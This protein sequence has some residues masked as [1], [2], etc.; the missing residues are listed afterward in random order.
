MSLRRVGSALGAMLRA[1]SLAFLVP[2][3]AA[4]VWEPRDLLVAGNAIPENTATFV[5][6]FLAI[7]LVAVPLGLATRSA[8]EED[9]T[10]REGYLTVALAWVLVP[11]F[12]MLPFELASAHPHAFDAYVEAMAAL[13]TTGFSTLADPG[14]M[15]P[16]LLLWRALLQWMGGLAIVALGMA[17]LSKLTHGGLRLAPSDA[18]VQASKRLRPKMMDTARSLLI[19]YASVTLVLLAV[20]AAILAGEGQAV[21]DAILDAA[22]LTLGA[23]STGGLA[24]DASVDHL[25]I[26]ALAVVAVGM[27]LGATSYQVVIAARSGNLRAALRDPEWRF[28]VGALAI[29]GLGLALVLLVAGFAPRDALLD[30]VWTAVSAITGTGFRHAQPGQ[31]PL[32]AQF[33]LLA[34]LVVGGSSGSA[35]GGVKLFRILILLKM[36]QRQ[37]RIL[38]HPRAVAPVRVGRTVVPDAALAT[39]VAFTF[40]YILLWL[41]GT[42]VLAALEPHL[43][44]MALASGAAASLGNVGLPFGGFAPEG[45]IAALGAGSK[46]VITFLMWAGRLEIFAALLLFYPASWRA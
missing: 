21:R 31:W 46:A 37:L 44:P 12:A 36:V 15:P 14:A 24:R 34:L 1:V 23:F 11:V 25:G 17:L 38:L 29:S 30:G 18:A 39:A 40:T 2:A 20:L 45:S 43:S 28:L 5:L 8:E 19:L 6:G 27:G 7:N 4:W 9:L 33:I 3:I 10:D 42:L 32:V 16:S 13:T 41:A 22:L 35:A 26:P